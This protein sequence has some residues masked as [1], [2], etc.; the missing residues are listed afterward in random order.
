MAALYVRDCF[1]LASTASNEA[2][3]MISLL[4]SGNVSINL[5]WDEG[6]DLKKETR[7]VL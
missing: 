3:S 7:G 1:T 4:A 5:L 2:P 6:K